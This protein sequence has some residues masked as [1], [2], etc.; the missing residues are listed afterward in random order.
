MQA[1]GSAAKGSDS[2][3]EIV[4][5]FGKSVVRVRSGFRVAYRMFGS[6]VCFL[7]FDDM[8]MCNGCMC[9]QGKEEEEGDGKPSG[10]G[11]YGLFLYFSNGISL[12]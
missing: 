3:K 4:G 8:S 11:G 1:L 5:V 6:A 2:S 10:G 9:A 12:V 7:R